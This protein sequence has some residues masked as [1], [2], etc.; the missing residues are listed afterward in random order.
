MGKITDLHVSYISLVA[1]PATGKS[2]VLRSE[3]RALT[4]EIKK[5]DAALQRAYGIVYAPGQMDSQGDYADA[6]VIRRAATKFLREYNQNN[7][8]AEH[9]FAAEMAGVAESWLVRKG[10]PTFPEEPDGAWA[11]GVQIYDPDLWSRLGKGELTGLSLAGMAQ[12]EQPPIGQKSEDAGLFA[13]FVAFLKG[14]PKQEQPPLPVEEADM[15]KE[16]MQSLL[17]SELSSL[18]GQAVADAMAKK[19]ADEAQ[20]AKEKARDAEVA[21]LKKSVESL[22][23]ALKAAGVKGAGESGGAGGVK[24]SF[25]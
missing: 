22:T 9:S 20:Q 7:V 6:D 18:V 1:R 23:E 17:K 21:D 12:Y 11:V 24:E 4:F 16:E 19:S 3:K 2:L 15:T 10:D 25:I 5:S 14:E 13:R 8:D